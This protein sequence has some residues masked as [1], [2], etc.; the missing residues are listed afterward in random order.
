[1]HPESIQK[2]ALSPVSIYLDVRPALDSYDAVFD[3]AYVSICDLI[4]V[5][6]LPWKSWNIFSKE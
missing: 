4:G 6:A 1:M 2:Q 3:R 5:K